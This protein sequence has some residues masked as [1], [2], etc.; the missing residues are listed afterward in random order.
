MIYATDHPHTDGHGRNPEMV[1]WS[2]A[3]GEA[4]AAIYA[5]GADPEIC[6]IRTMNTL[7]AYWITPEQCAALKALGVTITDRWGLM[8]WCAR[9]DGREDRLKVIA[10]FRK[11]G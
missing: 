1:C 3:P 4:E 6:R 5:V 9:R 2:D 11:A 8:E 10:E 7:H